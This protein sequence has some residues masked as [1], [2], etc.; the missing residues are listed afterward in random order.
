MTVMVQGK[1][2]FQRCTWQSIASRGAGQRSTTM[3][4]IIYIQVWCVLGVS[5]D[6]ASHRLHYVY[7]GWKTWNN[8]HL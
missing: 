4:A 7:T 1:H 6:D 3:P 2:E 8:A 5:A